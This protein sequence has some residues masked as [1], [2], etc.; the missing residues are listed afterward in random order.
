MVVVEGKL[1]CIEGT[2]VR[3]VEQ[4]RSLVLGLVLVFA[5]GTR[6]LCL[7][8]TSALSSLDWIGF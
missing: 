7:D 8:F 5:Y 6:D 1:H 3:G 4:S 2:L